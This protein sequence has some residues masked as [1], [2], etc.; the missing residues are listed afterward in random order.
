MQGWGA[1]AGTPGARPA[2]RAPLEALAGAV[3]A[4]PEARHSPPGP[5]YPLYREP[6]RHSVAV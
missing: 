3:A 6:P 1:G 5:L 4:V 2:P